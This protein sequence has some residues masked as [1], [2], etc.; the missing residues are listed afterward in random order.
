MGDVEKKAVVDI[1][2]SIA[3][4][5][6]LVVEDRLAGMR[7]GEI[8]SVLCPDAE[9]KFDLLKIVKN[10]GHRCIEAADTSGCFRVTIEKRG[11]NP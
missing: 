8:V 4:I 5:S 6:L 10:S 2:G 11:G 7:S 1:R 9:T 3:P